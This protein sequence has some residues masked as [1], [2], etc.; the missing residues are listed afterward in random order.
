M[1]KREYV[2][3]VYS[4]Y[5]TLVITLYCFKVWCTSGPHSSGVVV[6]E[7]PVQLAG[8][9]PGHWYVY[10]AFLQSIFFLVYFILANLLLFFLSDI[11][12]QHL[13]DFV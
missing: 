3:Q 12:I 2:A 13:S 10:P 11:E 5:V 7:G 4:H 8:C 9:M 6:R 1:H